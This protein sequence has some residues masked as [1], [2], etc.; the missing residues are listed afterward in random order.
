MPGPNIGGKNEGGDKNEKN[1]PELTVRNCNSSLIIGR[2]LK[3]RLRT[4]LDSC[5]RFICQF[6]DLRQSFKMDTRSPMVETNPDTHP[7]IEKI[8]D[9]WV[10]RKCRLG[11]RRRLN[12]CRLNLPVWRAEN[13][14]LHQD[15]STFLKQDKELDYDQITRFT[16][17]SYNQTVGLN[18][19]DLAELA[20]VPLWLKHDII[21]VFCHPGVTGMMLV[22]PTSEFSRQNDSRTLTKE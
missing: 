16:R 6:G 21:G 22:G 18:E 19:T 9:C 7:A 4:G 14:I 12:P 1:S 11:S 5:V 15:M 10:S 3:T 8:V 2:L 17:L 13:S 20:P